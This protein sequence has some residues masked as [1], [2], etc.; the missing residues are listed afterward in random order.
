MWRAS[1]AHRRSAGGRPT[2]L[3]M[4][5]AFGERARIGLYG[6]SFNPAHE[7]HAH[8]ARTALRRLDLDKVVWLVSPQNPLKVGKAAAPLADRLRGV[9]RFARGRSMVVSN[10]EE[11][12]GT[13]YSIDT[14]RAMKARFP[15]ARFVWIMG[16]DSLSNFHRWR[17]WIDILREI[18]VAVVARPGDTIRCRFSPAARRFPESRVPDRAANVL[19]YRQHPAWVYL[20]APL[21]HASSTALRD[22]R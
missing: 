9:K 10:A 21:N 11:R 5:L 6:G 22:G 14:I 2:A 12:F 19:V 16:A 4:G 13:R 20:T 15:G 8:V 1:S 18:P 17:G 7:G 3:R